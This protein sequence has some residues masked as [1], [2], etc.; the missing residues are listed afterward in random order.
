VK[1]YDAI[2]VG[3]GINGLVAASLLSK[4]GWSVALMERN[5]RL[6]GFIDSG[7]RTIPGYTHD[8]FSSW[9]PLFHIGGAYAALGEDLAKHGLEYLNTD[10]AITASVGSDGRAFVAHRDAAKTAAE[11][12]HRQDRDAYLG[13]LDEF[14]ELADVIGTV[15][16]AELTMPTLAKQVWKA[17]RRKGRT[18]TELLARD[19]VSS[20]RA[21]LDRRFTG[22]E[23][24]RTWAPWLLHSGLG[25]EHA[26]GGLMIPVFAATLHGAGMPIVKGGAANFVAA[27]RSLL[28]ANGVDIYTDTTVDT[29]VLAAGK[30][31]G[32]K[33]GAEQYAARKAVITSV[34]PNALYEQLLHPSAV[35]ARVAQETKQY[36]YGRGAM[37][38]HVALSEPLL[39]TDERLGASPLVHVTDGAAGT[40]VSCAQAAAGIIP[41]EPTIVVG[42]QY[43]LDPSRV[44]AGAASL[45]LQLQE[46]PFAPTADAGGT[47]DVSGGW[48]DDLKKGYLDRV[49]ARLAQHAPD[50]E[51]KIRSVDILSPEDLA[52]ENVNAVQG[53]PYSGAG[54]LDQNLLWRPGPA[55]AHHLTAVGN[56]WHIGASTHPGPGLGG[57]SG[58]LVA[59]RLSAKR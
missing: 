10:A 36:R 48:T 50:L 14:G 16:S 23:V 52:R 57:G 45:W 53:D 2:V 41:T 27:F 51:S 33:V 3:S 25:P 40:A 32:V 47:L 5:S 29:V 54:E 42:Q 31:V 56:L 12:E 28:E 46:V 7:E 37:Q 8:T 22:W 38:V 6:G 59:E 39:W 26:S 21:Y 11:L 18:G 34:T 4:R 43:L 49:V 15:L 9:H 30:A 19:L 1:S 44:P 55:A 13:M 58:F 35:P 17:F 24:D 20:G